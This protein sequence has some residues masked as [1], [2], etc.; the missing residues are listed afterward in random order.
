MLKLFLVI[1]LSTTLANMAAK[2]QGQV[3]APTGA[4]PSPSVSATP[5]PT[6][7]P[8]PIPLAEVVAQAESAAASLRDTEAD[9]SSDQLTAAI[10][11]ELSAVTREIDVRLAEDSRAL[12]PSPS[13][14]TLRALESG[15]QKIDD[16]LN[17]WE[18]D[19][20]ASAGRLEKKIGE[21]ARRADTWEQTL[22]LAQ[23][24]GGTPPEV[25][26]RIEAVIAATR[27]T[28]AAVE[29]RR[30]Q[31]L[32][33]QNRVVGQSARVKEALASIS[34]ARELAVN[35][36]FVR[37][38]PPIW[39]GEVRS[40]AG[41]N[42]LVE[43]RSSFREQLTAL[44]TYAGRHAGNFFLHV[45]LI[46]I[47]VAA[48]YWVRR[49]VKPWVGEEPSV[50]H[51]ALVFERP[52]A[53]AFVLSILA[54][55]WIYP[56]A[57][58]LW[59]AVLGAVALI[60]TIIIL[61]RLVEPRL[62]PVLNA[63]VV[64]NFVDLLRA[65]VASLPFTSRFLFLFEMLTGLLFLAWFVKSARSSPPPEADGGR[66]W[67]TVRTAAGVALAGFVL[68]FV[69]SVLGYVGLATLVGDALLGSAYLAV[70]LYAAAR[71]ADGLIM[72]ALRVRP[73]SLLGMVRENRPLFRRRVRGAVRALAFLIWLLVTLERLSLRQPLFGLIRD[74]LTARLVVGSLGISLGNVLAFIITVW[75]AFL[76]S[77]F[78]RF[79]LE[80]DV[81]PRL[82]LARGVP[83]AVST[84]L[85]Y[86]I[87]VFG[88]F[89]AV[90]AMGIDMTRFTILAGAFGVGLGFGLQ[91]I[92]N[93]FVS[94]LIVL[95]ERPVKVGDSI[96]MS[97]ASGTVKR[98]G[99]RASVISAWNGSDIIVPNGK[100]I[101]E[102]VTNWTPL[103]SRRG[104]AIKV[105]VAH[106]TDPGR[107]I[108]LLRGV[109]AAHELVASE[110]PPE[111]LMIEF[112]AD[113]LNFELRAWTYHNKEWEQVR[114]DL[115][116]AVNSVFAA[117]GISM[118]YPQR[119]LHLR[120][121][122]T[123]ALRHINKPG[124]GQ[125]DQVSS[126]DR[127]TTGAEPESS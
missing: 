79:V 42:L 59:G 29:R 91:N 37:D 38:S 106:G 55:G 25:L 104:I 35:R 109:A 8:T 60:P 124:S 89:L 125:S 10:E 83:Y 77:R 67:K 32:T 66:L 107:V 87:L 21:L 13:L 100:L 36:L 18:R 56:L 93:N 17:A 94:G 51:A 11:T 90:A 84:M 74:V 49:R 126:S 68:A 46:I 7:T 19:L 112:G 44:G 61:R 20:R 33:L 81:Y 5:T 57:P 120:S 82:T 105:G 99:I 4:A 88:F 23:G 119:D 45:V 108:E 70:I 78:I 96:Q 47:L 58:R 65:V 50:R 52:V 30:A 9:L 2:G 1:A 76:L 28:R 62:F 24:E 73:L 34:Q 95:F 98:I 26:Q 6:P 102:S 72:F 41:Q 64:F 43:G 97:E 22:A 114:S 80:E 113:S 53:A 48:L 71:I 92:F 121:I 27:Q 54:G 123:E 40:H 118:P 63:L 15:W 103:S 85:N 16:N 127:A 69:A 3:S 110:P 111:A 116:V 122:D 14:E 75:A 12:S 86:A 115:A 117:E 31:A 39:S 101:S